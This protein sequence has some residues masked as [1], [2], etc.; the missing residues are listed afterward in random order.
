M[1]TYL[2][3]PHGRL[4]AALR[5]A[6]AVVFS[7]GF[8][9]VVIDKALPAQAI[10]P[11]FQPWERRELVVVDMTG[12]RG[13]HGAVQ[14]AVADWDGR[15]SGADLRLTLVLGSGPCGYEPGRI[16]VC[17]ETYDRLNHDVLL[18]IE[19]F[20]SQEHDGHGRSHS[21]RV[22]VCADC[23]ATPSRQRV[24]AA[25]EL[26]HA[27]GLE[28]N[29]RRESLMYHGGGSEDPDAGDYQALRAMYHHGPN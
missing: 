11:Q 14:H 24:I 16:S 23:D 9:T 10:R 22:F 5:L 27:L 17:Q 25:H 15:R 13:W 1:R 2:S 28:H 26:G 12:D 4:L 20:A 19:G 3:L 18:P 7:L 6:N 8:A 21:A 29:N